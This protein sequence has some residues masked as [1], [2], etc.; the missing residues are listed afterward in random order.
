MGLRWFSPRLHP[1]L[2]DHPYEGAA[3]A[4]NRSKRL[5]N[6][7]KEATEAQSRLLVASG[8]NA[9]AGVSNRANLWA[10]DKVVLASK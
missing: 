5:Q 4:G 1:S 8:N 3:K 10:W 6:P 9:K 7:D 2:W